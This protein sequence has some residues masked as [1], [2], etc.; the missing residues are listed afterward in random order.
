MLN[1]VPTNKSCHN[2]HLPYKTETCITMWKLETTAKGN[3]VYIS[4]LKQQ[5]DSDFEFISVSV[6]AVMVGYI[7]YQH[8]VSLKLYDLKIESFF[9]LLIAV[10]TLKKPFNKEKKYILVCFYH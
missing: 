5:G 10:S 7:R 1:I 4:L 8:T 9:S 2:Y 6:S 3:F